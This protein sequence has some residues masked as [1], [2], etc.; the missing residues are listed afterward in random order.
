NAGLWDPNSNWR[1]AGYMFNEFKFS[2]TTKAQIAGR[3]EQV[4]L[5]GMAR[6]FDAV[7]NMTTTPASPSYTPMSASMGLIQKLPWN[8]VGSITAQ[9]VER[10]PKPAELFSGGP[11]DATETFDK[12]NT[13]LQIEVAKSVEIG[14][15]RAT[16]PF[17]F[18]VTAYYTRFNNF[19][20]RNLTGNTCDPDTAVCG[21]DAG[22]L[23]EAIYS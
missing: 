10:A 13:G 1:I 8:L 17:R 16:A 14:L 11:H 12:G 6:S 4:D 21:P 3:I 19:I 15:R 22:E 18:E 2:E 23:R 5:S 20:F 7:G 9:Y